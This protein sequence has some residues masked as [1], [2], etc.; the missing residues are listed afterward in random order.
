MDAGVQVICSCALTMGVPLVLAGWELWKLKPPQ[1]RPPPGEPVPRE[2]DPLPDAGVL[3]R[4]QK[5][6][7]D[8]LIPKPA[9]V[10]ELA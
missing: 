2:P 4:V 8:C 9:R 6:L 5:P 7:P 3:P 10:R 1:W